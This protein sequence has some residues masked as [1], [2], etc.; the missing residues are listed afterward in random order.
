MKPVT[1]EWVAKA[2]EDLL[3]AVDLGRRRKRPVWDAVCFH[4][5]QATE[6]YLKARLHE[7]GLAVPR[8][9]DLESLLNLLLPAEPLWSAFRPALQDLSDYAVDFRY[10]GHR[11][12][13]A[14]ARRALAD[15]KAVRREVRH[16]LG[17]SAA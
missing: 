13:K 10:P 4:C 6:K 8:T 17:L 5:Q 11:A 3:A 9:H 12:T 16:S 15:C 2:E 14:K 1:R 7:A